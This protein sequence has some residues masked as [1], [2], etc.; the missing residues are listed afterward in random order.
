MRLERSRRSEHV[1]DRRG[2]GLPR[3]V[4]IGGAGGIGLLLL[5]VLAVALGVDPSAVLEQMGESPSATA[6]SEQPGGTATAPDLV[7][8]FVSAVLAE[9]EDVWS[10]VFRSAGRTYDPPRL[11]LFTGAVESACG[12][13]QSAVGPFYCP[14]D[15]KVYLDYGFFKDLERLGASGDFAE[16]YVIAHEVGHHVQT[17]LGVTERLH[18]LQAK[19][20]PEERNAL[21]V[22]FELQ[23]D[24]LAGIWAHRA[25]RA[26]Q[27]LEAGD[28]E[29]GLNA[30]SAVG[31]DRIQRR[32]R[33]QVVPDSFTH[34]SSAQRTHWFSRGLRSG[35]PGVCDMSSLSP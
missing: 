31:D 14:L 17:L 19:G 24:C 23:A 29:E 12:I 9:T 32:T 27:I 8:N 22:R 16:A 34:G 26:R 5:V 21:S 30:A 18:S 13:A 11:V 25:D 33:G 15:R 10:E 2:M 7:R 6:P 4:R 3:S 1:E 28:V 35:E 20:S